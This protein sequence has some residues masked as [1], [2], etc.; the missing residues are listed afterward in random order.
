MSST[1][2]ASR[3]VAVNVVQGDALRYSADVLA[4]KY[5]QRFHDVDRLVHRALAEGGVAV[6]PEEMPAPGRHLLVASDGAVAAEA[7]MFVGVAKLQ[8]FRYREI[9][10]FSRRVLTALAAERPDARSVAM[11]LHGPGYGLDE[12]ESFR[13]EVA[14]LVDAVTTDACP[15]ALEAVT[16]VEQDEEC[17]DVLEVVLDELAPGGAIMA[18]RCQHVRRLSASAAESFRSAGYRSADK[19]HVFVA[20]PF[21]KR[22]KDVYLYGI[23]KPVRELGFLCER[24]DH[25]VFTGDVLQWVRERI[26]TADLVIADLTGANPNV[27]L[28][29]G[30]AWGCGKPTLL[31]ADP[32]EKLRFDVQGH[33]CLVYDTI[34]DLEEKLRAELKTL[35]RP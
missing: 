26:E 13:A 14:G 31:L 11:T 2:Q 32:A 35:A 22:M 24:A 20:M 21:E 7:V 15:A 16:F 30:Y 19:P 33:R 17:F 10:E 28:E 18:D 9:R 25:A 4:V 3:K 12:A 27:Y 5:P 23:E 6:R 29:V 34:S 1:L 8:A